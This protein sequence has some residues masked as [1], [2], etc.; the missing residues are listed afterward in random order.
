MIKK[1]LS[2][3]LPNNIRNRRDFNRK[4]DVHNYK[5]FDFLSSESI[6]LD[7]GANKGDVSNYVNIVSQGCQIFCYEP[8]PGA[9]D[10]LRKRFEGSKNIYLFNEAISDR[11]G[12]ATMYL[13]EN[14]ESQTDL[15]YSQGTS[16]DVDKVNVDK[17]KKLPVNCTSIDTIL[18]KFDYI[19][20][21][22]IDIEGHEYQI[23][24][25]IILN[26]NKVG[27]VI[28]ELHGDSKTP[29]FIDKH[30]SLINNLRELNLLDNWFE[31]W[32]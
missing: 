14:S 15:K 5:L 16:F 32:H 19:D 4:R 7:I 27:K 28:C 1:F 8:H 31:R 22:K 2:S 30:N 24:D 18:D 9:F 13:H 20:C 17:S 12:M 3:L 6:F 29:R 21:I 25:Q 11:E 10:F 23:L 26:R